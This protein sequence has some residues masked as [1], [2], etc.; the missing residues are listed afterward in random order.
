M[1]KADEEFMRE[2]L[3][4]ARKAEAAGEVPVGAVLV[5]GIER[6]ISQHVLRRLR[7][8]LLRHVIDVLV[9]PPRQV[10]ALQPAAFLIDAAGSLVRRHEAVGVVGEE[11]GE[12]DLLGISA[13]HGEGIADDGPLRLAE[14][15]KDL[16][17]VVDQADDDEP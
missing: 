13:S 6:V 9:V 3:V 5:P 15:A 17:Q 14:Q 2:A 4:L 12:D 16:A 1:N 8:I 11:L 10:D 7:Q